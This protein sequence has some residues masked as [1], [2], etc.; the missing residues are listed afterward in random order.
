M[1]K[2]LTSLAL[3]ISMTA[4][5]NAATHTFS[6]FNQFVV[7]P[8]DANANIDPTFVQLP[9]APANTYYGYSVSFNWTNDFDAQSNEAFFAFTNAD[10]LD[11]MIYADPGSSPSSLVN[12][13]P[14]SLAWSGYFNAPYSS[15]GPLYFAMAQAWDQSS[16]NWNNISI[17]LYANGP[18]SSVPVAG[19]LTAAPTYNR[20]TPSGTQL[21][22]IGTA[23]RYQAV[24]FYVDTATTYEINTAYNNFDGITFVH[25]GAFDPANPLASY[26][27]GQDGQQ[28]AAGDSDQIGNL[29]LL[30]NIQYYLVI[31]GRTNGD[32]GTFT[33]T[34]DSATPLLS[35]NVSLGVIPEPATLGVLIAGAGAMLARRKRG[36]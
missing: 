10:N 17:T 18:R 4:T 35:G 3:V 16:A 33:G 26:L 28:D 25:Q 19:N 14:A 13:Q 29:P 1:H 23:V 7:N 24:P 9:T 30:P 21:S 36:S 8:P 32:F 20:P 15:P 12:G 6:P 22:S 5:A 34:I 11:N 2:S 27:I 31:S